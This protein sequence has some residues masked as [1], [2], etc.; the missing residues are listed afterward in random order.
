MAAGAQPGPGFAGR[1]AE[2]RAGQ[3]RHLC[4]AG[5]VCPAGGVSDTRTRFLP[6]ILRGKGK[7]VKINAGKATQ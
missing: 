2:P 6:L 5:D 7:K 4:E 1:G 3:R